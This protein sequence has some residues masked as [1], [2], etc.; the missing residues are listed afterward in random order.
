MQ[1]GSTEGTCG[2]LHHTKAS[3]AEVNREDQGREV[4]V[5]LKVVVSISGSPEAGIKPKSLWHQ[6][7]VVPLDLAVFEMLVTC[8]PKAC[9]ARRTLSASL[10]SLLTL[11]GLVLQ[12]LTIYNTGGARK[13]CLSSP[14]IS[15]LPQ[16]NISHSSAAI[17]N[18]QTVPWLEHLRLH[19]Q[20]FL[21]NSNHLETHF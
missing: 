13:C 4:P 11:S 9:P 5:V 16:H 14:L 7:D 8:K 6:L 19:T 1:K 21:C 3:T 17:V 10:T 15:C 2:T 18:S 12:S 20:H